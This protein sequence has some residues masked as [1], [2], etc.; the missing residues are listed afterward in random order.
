MPRSR[1]TALYVAR[2]ILTDLEN[3][4]A[5]K[6][7]ARV[8]RWLELAESG[9]KYEHGSA[10][11]YKAPGEEEG[12]TL[13]NEGV[14]RHQQQHLEEARMAYESAVLRFHEAGLPANEAMALRLLASVE[15]ELDR[16]PEA[17]SHL[18]QAVSIYQRMGNCLEEAYVRLV[19]CENC[20]KLGNFEEAL[21]EGQSG[22]RLIRRTGDRDNEALA[23][24]RQ[25]NIAR[26]L[27]YTEQAVAYYSS[28]VSLYEEL[29]NSDQA[30]VSLN[31]LATLFEEKGLIDKAMQCLSE[32]IPK[33]RAAGDV[34]GEILAEMAMASCLQ[35]SGRPLEA[36]SHL[37]QAANLAEDEDDIESLAAT[38]GRVGSLYRAL[39]LLEEAL[40]YHRQAE[41]LV[42]NLGNLDARGSIANNLG[43]VLLELDDLVPAAQWLRRAAAIA[44]QLGHPQ[45]EV[46][47]EN[48]IAHVELALGEADGA[49]QAAKRALLIAQRMADRGGEAIAL[50][51]LSLAELQLSQYPQAWEHCSQAV[52]LHRQLDHHI[53][54]WIAL[55]NMATIAREQQRF[56]EASRC[57]EGALVA[58]E[59]VRSQISNADL[60]AFYFASAKNLP[61]EYADHL[62]THGELARAFYIVER[63]KARTLLELFEQSQVRVRQD[64]DPSLHERELELLRELYQTRLEM[65]PT[66][67]GGKRTSVEELQS[68]V[69]QLELNLYLVQAELYQRSH[70]KE[71][72]M[73]SEPWDL[74]S[75]QRRVLDSKTVLLEYVLGEPV[76]L[77]FAVAL[78]DA[79]VHLLPGRTQLESMIYELRKA[80]MGG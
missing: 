35:Q 27:G 18:R 60:R 26:R 23:N 36:L 25:G 69:R 61:L 21:N 12:E 52:N 48:N 74:E 65:R 76:S 59:S 54:E 64:V 55:R 30:G 68:R 13:L 71:P 58:L 38:L 16:P 39:G 73:A 9:K 72:S 46:I 67:P 14:A 17:F 19:I 77:L 70:H 29:G 20:Q 3:S 45:R 15:M 62:A 41:T 33:L 7:A 40:Q 24:N 5:E 57:Y 51:N 34:Y 56:D 32:S 44:R 6:D 47:A 11:Q 42:G 8:R 66:T 4:G 1:Q 37:Q 10:H 80:V 2:S 75:I 50:N 43:P 28:A 78:N 79:E 31:N 22:L 53:D 63:S 49:V